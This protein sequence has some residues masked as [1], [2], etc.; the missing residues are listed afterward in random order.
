MELTRAIDLYCERLGPG[1]WAE[2]WNLLSNLSFVVAGVLGLYHAHRCGV[3]H[4]WQIRY[5][6]VMLVAIGIGSGL[7][8]SFANAVTQAAD[9]IPIGIHV[10]SFAFLVP[11]YGLLWSVPRSLAVILALIVGSAVFSLVI[12]QDLVNGSQMYF[13]AALMQLGLAMAGR[14]RV[15]SRALFYASGLFFVSLLLRSLDQAVCPEFPLGTHW[16]WHLCNGMV[17]YLGLK[18]FVAAL[19]GKIWWKNSKSIA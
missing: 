19:G 10:I 9:V 11:R 12:P 16:L 18:Y 14:R 3:G 1:L 17:L 6:S 2:P 4:L 5:S 13:G 15:R 8:H 7:F